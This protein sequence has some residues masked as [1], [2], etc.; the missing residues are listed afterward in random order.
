MK[1]A[2]CDDDKN[3]LFRILSVLADYQTQRN[4]EF[5]TN[6]STTVRNF[7][8]SFLVLFFF[9]LAMVSLDFSNKKSTAERENLLL[10]TAAV[11]AQKEITQLSTSQKQASIYRHDLRHH[12][13]FLQNCIAE[14]EIPISH[15]P[16]HGLGT[17]SMISVVEK[18]HGV[19]GFFAEDGKFRPILQIFTFLAY[20]MLQR[21]SKNFFPVST[22]IS[23]SNNNNHFNILYYFIKNIL[24][25]VWHAS[26]FLLFQIF[27][28]YKWKFIREIS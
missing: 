23:N 21:G 19:Y 5:P 12:M 1:I 6:L 17:K 20:F 10:T 25:F 3:E 14:N 7:M 28:L 24:V 26:N 18:Y 16:N 8:D 4:I 9:I 2:I 27:I 15:E 13:T 22:I 11:Q